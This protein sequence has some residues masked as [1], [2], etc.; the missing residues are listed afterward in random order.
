MKEKRG[1]LVKGTLV[2]L[3]MLVAFVSVTMH[4]LVKTEAQQSDSVQTETFTI[5]ALPDG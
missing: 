4:F 5:A 2:L 3:V 1:L